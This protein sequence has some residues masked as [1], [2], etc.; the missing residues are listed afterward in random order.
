VPCQARLYAERGSFHTEWTI[1]LPRAGVNEA[2]ELEGELID[3][4]AMT[5]TPLGR[6]F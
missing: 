1:D 3:T 2:L 5:I 4:W 6:R